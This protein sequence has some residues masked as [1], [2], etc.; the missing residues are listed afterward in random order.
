MSRDM[1]KQ[2]ETLTHV[3]GRTVDSSV[4]RPHKRTFRDAWQYDP[5]GDVIT[6]N[7]AKA[8]DIKRAALRR[9]RAEKLAELDWQQQRALVSGDNSSAKKIEEQKQALRDAPSHK[10][11][12]N[13]KKPE[14]L[15]AITLDDLT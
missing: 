14:D 9:E 8:R 12:S 1:K 11:I 2:P 6:V 15:E 4:E 3:S 10:K 7:M 5:D 13:A